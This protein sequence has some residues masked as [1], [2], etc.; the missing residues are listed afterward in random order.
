MEMDKDHILAEIRRTALDNG[1]E[2]LGLMRFAAATGIRESDWSGR[3]WARWSEAVQEAGLRPNR[4]QPR[5]E[6][7][8]VLL[9]LV[10]EVRRLG[11]LPTNNE[12]RL[13]HREDGT[14]PSH[15]V[16]SRLGTKGEIAVKLAD[17]CAQQ[18]DL[19]DIASAVRNALDVDVEAAT[20]DDRGS[21]RPLGAGHVY[22][23][24]VG[25][26]YKLGRSKAFGRRERELAIQL[27][28]RA[29][30][31][32]VI[33][34]DDPVGIEAYWHARFAERRSNGEWFALSAA[35]VKAFRRRKFM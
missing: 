33:A 21:A 34:T 17:Y 2:P 19:A 10:S 13:R 35:D 18:P 32:H 30:T 25:R 4:L 23:L 27:P 1:G 24:K 16:F 31:V 15:G 11:R 12:L 22:L 6:D 9:R 8:D 20:T 29:Q 5:F 28:E 14:F 3:F 26:H 7:A